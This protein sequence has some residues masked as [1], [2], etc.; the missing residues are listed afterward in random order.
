VYVLPVVIV[1]FDFIGGPYFGFKPYLVASAD[2]DTSHSVCQGLYATL[3]WGLEISVGVFVKVEFLGVTLVDW[4][5]KAQNV[6]SAQYPITAGCIS[7]GS[8]GFTITPVRSIR[9][10]RIS[11][12]S[13]YRPLSRCLGICGPLLAKTVGVL[14]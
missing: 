4:E 11:L 3:N 8:N 1:K 14:W 10:P 5:S 12:Y 7:F 13:I 9:L 2:Y 6:Y